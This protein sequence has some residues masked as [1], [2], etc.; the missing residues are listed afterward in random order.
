MQLGGEGRLE[1]RVNPEEVSRLFGTKA[2]ADWRSHDHQAVPKRSEQK[3]QHFIQ[4]KIAADHLF[5]GEFGEQHAQRLTDIAANPGAPDFA[6]LL[7]IHSGQKRHAQD[8]MALPAPIE[9]HQR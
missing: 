9:G 5:P 2:F 7:V 8:G 6:G 3:F 4:V 1:S